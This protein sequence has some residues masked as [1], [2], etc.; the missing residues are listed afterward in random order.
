MRTTV[1][2]PDPLYLRLKTSAAAQGRSVKALLLEA[3]KLALDQ[4]PTGRGR[5][6][7]VPPVRSRHPG[8]LRIDNA[9]IYELIDFP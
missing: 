1:D 6:L 3:A 2:I 7:R 4:Q 9:R 8:T 5:R